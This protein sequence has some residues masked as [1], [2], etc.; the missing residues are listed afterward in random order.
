MKRFSWTLLIGLIALEAWP[1]PIEPAQFVARVN[2]Y[3]TLKEK[4]TAEV[5]RNASQLHFL[6]VKGFLSEGM[7]G[8]Y[9]REHVSELKQ[10]GV[11]ARQISVLAPCSGS[12]LEEN[13]TEL[14]ETAQRVAGSGRRLVLIGHS[15]GAV[16]VLAF[17]VRNPKFVEDHVAAIFLIQGAFGGSGVADFLTGRGNPLD[18]RI[19][20][21]YRQKLNLLADGTP[22]L[23]GLIGIDEGLK[24]L[25][26][27]TAGDFWKKMLQ[28][29][30]EATQ[31]IGPKVY[32]I[33]GKQDPKK[34][35]M[36]VQVTGYY[37]HYS[38]DCAASG[39]EKNTCPNDGLVH[40]RDQ[41]VA[42]LGRPLAIFQSDHAGLTNSNPISNLPD[43]VRRSLTR[44]IFEA[45]G[46]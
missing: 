41:S 14:K 25:T 42:G 29:N 26:R 46:H 30:G 31:S 32:Y 11:P 8:L 13:Q 35:A 21:L 17:A 5:S 37:L 9:F 44:A 27:A 7:P 22:L 28:E 10:L 20:W 6:F 36:V 38:Y 19:P 34:M 1:T 15:R 39:D 4:P 3:W 2:H 43:Y 24:E 40:L 18:E 45:V 16:D 12:S 33:L 23:G